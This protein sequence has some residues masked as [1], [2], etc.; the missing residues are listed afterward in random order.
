MPD[1]LVIIPTLNERENIGRMVRKVMSLPAGFDLLVVDDLSADGTAEIVKSL[2]PEFS[3]RLFLEERRGRRGLGPA[4]LHGFRWALG[5]D[6]AYVFEMDG[7]FSH[8]PEDLVRLRAA[9]VEGA[10]VAVGS[11]YVRGGGVK[12]WAWHRRLLSHFASL[13]VR[14]VLLFHVRDTTAGFKCYR[15]RVLEGLDLGK[16]RFA[17]YAF[18]IEMKYTAHRV[19]FR[20][21]EVPIVFV[22][23]VEGQSKMSLRIFREALWGVLQLRFSK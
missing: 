16:V 8:D 6:Y 14:A 2:Q 1:S 12:N 13:Y 7:D 23:R 18:Q 17:G 4:Y 3:G 20:V 5:R 21:A 15:R 22:D 19:G 9:C 11:R 10:D